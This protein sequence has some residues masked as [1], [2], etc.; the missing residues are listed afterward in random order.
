M[1]VF[2]FV[3]QDWRLVPV[4]IELAL[5][6]GLPMIRL[7]GLPDQA[8][9]ESAVRIR[10]AI[11]AQGFRLP[12]GKQIL[13]QLR[14]HDQRKSSQGLDLA[15]AAAL[16]WE[17]KQIPRWSVATA[18]TPYLYGELTLG[19]Q[20]IAPEDLSDAD[21]SESDVLVTGQNEV[22]GSSAMVVL[23]ELKDLSSTL[24]IRP[25]S[26]ISESSWRRPQVRIRELPVDLADLAE[27]VAAGEH[28]ALLAGP[29]GAGKSTLVD[30]VASWL[31]PPQGADGVR[32]ARRKLWRPVVRPHHSITPKGMIGGG[33]AL[34]PGEMARA[35]TGILILD[36]LL[37]F[38]PAIQE[39]LREPLDSG[40]LS[41]ARSGRHRSISTRVLLLAT[42]N[43]CDCGHF[44]P[45]EREGG[46]RCSI[47]VRSRILNRLS[48][49]FADRFA[50][51]FFTRQELRAQPTRSVSEIAERVRAAIDFRSVSRGQDRP[52]NQLEIE[53]ILPTLSSLQTDF[54]F[55]A[56]DR[57]SQR[58]REAVLRLA[59]TFADLRL[60]LKVSHRDLDQALK[61]GFVGH[62]LLEQART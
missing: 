54:I 39:A 53:A 19:G 9:R 61:L 28:S 47:R 2:S 6:P 24:K 46:C 32:A 17:T 51:V 26:D 20:V 34:W 41:L 37:E 44:I 33:A 31:E 27:V 4:E 36:E 48:G 40:D 38:H 57:S 22:A 52:N 7:I 35:D 3:R 16:L 45:G 62:R 50:V 18:P 13:V 55:E 59:R 14:P 5:V 8:M 30:A 21:C 11:R 12:R 42:T 29:H 58:R 1:R 25:G 49:P 56:L 23:R 43:L 10:A 15:V 60:S